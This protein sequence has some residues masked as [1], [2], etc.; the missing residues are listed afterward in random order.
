MHIIRKTI[1]HVTANIEIIVTN[2]E[3]SADKRDSR[4]FA[5]CAN[6]AICPITV[7]SPVFITT[8]S[9]D[10]KVHEVPKKARFAVSNGLSEVFFR[11]SQQI[12]RFSC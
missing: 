4:A 2:L 8:P 12:F 5:D 6:E 7:L 11:F 10:P 3:I 1:P 9:P